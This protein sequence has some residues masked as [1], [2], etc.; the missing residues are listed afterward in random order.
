MQRKCYQTDCAGYA[1]CWG[2][3]EREP[4]ECGGDEAKCDFYEEVR[5][6]A[7]VARSRA[8][9]IRNKSDEELAKWIESI[10]S[11]KRCP[12]YRSGK[13]SGESNVSRA[14]CV[15]R[16]LVWLQQ[17][18]EDPTNDCQGSD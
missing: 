4:C 2:T 7:L 13:C 16:W 17:M 8:A 10:A 18:K 11:C 12:I 9:G 1:V 3:R 15:S 5:Q 6:K 14:S